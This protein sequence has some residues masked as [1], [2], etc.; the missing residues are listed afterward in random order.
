V[1]REKLG[2]LPGELFDLPWQGHAHARTEV[3]RRARATADLILMLDADMLVEGLLPDPPYADAYRLTITGAW[4]YTL[5]LLFSG[6]RSWRYVGVTHPFP[7]PDDELAWSAEMSDL[8]IT[9]RRPGAVRQGKLEEDA[10]A[11]EAALEE[12]PIDAR[13]SYYLAQTYADLGRT[14][15][16]IREFGRRA[17]LGGWDEEVFVAKLRRGRLLQERDPMQA[18]SAFLDS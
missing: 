3:L 16:A 2:H 15:D 14:S 1:V 4:E 9:D 17:L 10:R 7:E 6:E 12:N 8:R 18:L 13:S 5:L 11:L